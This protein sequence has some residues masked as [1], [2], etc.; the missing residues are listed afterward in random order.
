MNLTAMN[1]IAMLLCTQ[2]VFAQ[3]PEI[4]WQKAF[5][6]VDSDELTAIYQ[7]TDGGY[8][9]GGNSY[10]GISGD[11]SEASWGDT[12]YWIVKVN[13]EGNIEWENSIGGSGWDDLVSVQQTMDGG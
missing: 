13:S 2:A 12:D 4:Q 8:I 3:S 7:T 5:G 6:G 1:L 9:L 10:S 11:K